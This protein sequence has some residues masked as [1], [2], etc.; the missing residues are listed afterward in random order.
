MFELKR[1]KLP[2]TEYFVTELS[3][4]AAIKAIDLLE[5]A[6]TDKSKYV[7][8]CI[9]ATLNCLVDESGRTVYLDTDIEK[10]KNASF[11]SINKVCEIAL[12]L[13]GLE[14]DQAGN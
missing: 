14:E 7:E 11:D 1:E 9:H 8:L 5:G 6:I 13:S 10:V 12:S 3:A 2:N 4:G